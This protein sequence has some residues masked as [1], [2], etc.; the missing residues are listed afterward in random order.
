MLHYKGNQLITRRKKSIPK[1]KKLLLLFLDRFKFDA[2]C[3]F[4]RLANI[5][6]IYFIINLKKGAHFLRDLKVPVSVRQIG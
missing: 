2:Y 4:H 1:V 6:K 3:T 5:L